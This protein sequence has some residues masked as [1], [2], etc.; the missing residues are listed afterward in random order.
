MVFKVVTRDIDTKFVSQILETGLHF[1]GK[2]KASDRRQRTIILDG[3]IDSQH[4]VNRCFGTL[5]VYKTRT[6]KAHDV[7]IDG[8]SFLVRNL[9]L[10]KGGNPIS[11]QV[12]GVF[13]RRIE[14]KDLVSNNRC[15]LSVVLDHAT[16][17][18]HV[19]CRPLARVRHRTTD[20]R[21]PKSNLLIKIEV[22]NVNTKLVC[23]ALETSLHFIRELN[24]CDRRQRTV[25]LDG[26]IDSQHRVD[27]CFGTLLVFKA[28]INKTHNVSI[29]H[30]TISIGNLSLFE[31]SD[32][33]SSLIARVRDRRTSCNQSINIKCLTALRDFGTIT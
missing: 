11:R 4:R 22:G 6:D 18:K 5:L 10:T 33:L 15:I 7:S 16:E 32:P 8:G 21:V 24:T 17:R 20:L 25:I 23:H 3:A 26:A 2:F 9:I 30:A 27:R 19:A 14:C 29:N 28:R 31:S 1:V 12:A 13:D